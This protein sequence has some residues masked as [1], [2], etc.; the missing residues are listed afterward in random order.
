MTPVTP[1][2]NFWNH[3]LLWKTHGRGAARSQ[4]LKRAPAGPDAHPA[5]ERA[6]RGN[7]AARW[8]IRR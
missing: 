7:L 3:S 5:A 1:M 4:E 6:A 2:E 8:P